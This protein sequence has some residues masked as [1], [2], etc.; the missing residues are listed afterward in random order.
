[1]K[2]VLYKP[3]GL[4][5]FSQMIKK[6]VTKMSTATLVVKPLFTE[7]YIGLDKQKV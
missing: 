1:M 2:K 7:V 5:L 4:G 6:H 3:P